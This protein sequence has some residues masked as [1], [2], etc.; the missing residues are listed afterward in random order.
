MQKKLIVILLFLAPA[1]TF[2]AQKPVQGVF[3]YKASV[4][5]PDTNVVIKTWGVKVYTNDTIVRVETETDQMG[6]QVYIRHMEL[7]KAY[8]LLNYN[9]TNYAIQNNLGENKKSDTIPPSYTVKKKFGGKKIAGIRCKK[10]YIYD[11]TMK[12]G[13]DCYFAKKIGNKYLEVYPEIPGLAVDYYLPSQDGWIHYEL[14]SYVSGTVNR[15]LFGVP[16]DYKRVSF[17]EFIRLFN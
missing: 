16:S 8:L 5:H 6:Q 15:D 17:D 2:I 9:G 12:E 11:N 10:Y 13:F 4:T 14:T 7:Q 3:T 1:L